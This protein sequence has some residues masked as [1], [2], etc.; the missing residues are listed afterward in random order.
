[1]HA[2]WRNWAENQSMSPVA[3]EH[4][5]SV[6]EV[7]QVVKAAA[8]AGRRVKAIGSGHSFTSIGLT[9]GVLVQ[10]DRLDRLMSVDRG[11]GRVVV[12]GGMVLR[13]LNAL[14]A[15]HGLGLT[16]MGDVDAQ[17]VA[18]ALATGTHGTG[19]ESAALATQ[20]V[21]VAPADDV[22][23]STA[24]GRDTAYV[25][26]HVFRGT[27]H[28]AY[29]GAVEALMGELAAGRTGA[30]CTASAPGSCASATRASRRSSPCATGSTPSGASRTPTWTGCSAPEVVSPAAQV[31]RPGLDHVVAVDE[32][33]PLVQRHRRVDVRRQRPHQV[34][35]REGLAVQR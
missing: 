10:L 24:S 29:F 13:R 17:T 14:L 1:M 23:L 20:V 31:D 2:M 11:T 28:R 19:R 9:D 5:S 12:Q 22:A 4:P 15:E 27:D 16:N 30:S 18:G 26:A 8:A 35:H 34:A 7:V 33:H 21:R 3:V 32:V 25:A 6:D